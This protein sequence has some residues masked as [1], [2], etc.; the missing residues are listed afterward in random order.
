MKRYAPSAPLMLNNRT[1]TRAI[2]IRP[3]PHLHLH[4]H[5]EANGEELLQ[6]GRW[7]FASAARCS[8]SELPE[9]MRNRQLYQTETPRH[10]TASF[11]SITHSQHERELHG[12]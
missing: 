6:K 9:P 2:A 10:H 5:Q 4:L 7:R 3:F 11:R 12:L 8:R 1:Y